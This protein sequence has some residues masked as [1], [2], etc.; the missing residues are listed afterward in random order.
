VGKSRYSEQ[1]LDQAFSESVNKAWLQFYSQT[2]NEVRTIQESGLRTV[3][4][5]VLSPVSERAPVRKVDSSTVYQRVATFLARHSD[6][7]RTSLGSED[8]FKKRYEKDPDLRQI[9]D[10]LDNIERQIERAM[11]QVDSFLT[12]ISSLLSR[13]K[14]LTLSDNLLQVL[15]ADGRSLPIAGL[16]SGEKHLIKILLASMTAGPNSVLID[17][18]E[19]SMHIDWQRIFVKT[20]LSLNPNSQ[21]ILAT[22][23]PEVM[24]DMDDSWIFKL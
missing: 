5:Q 19:L 4:R 10:N 18:P 22:H 20:I 9:V 23:S 17:E 15:L 21:L 6:A 1:E 13:G 24:A 7:D 11:I 14:S 12:T 8:A 16:S 2:L 3:L